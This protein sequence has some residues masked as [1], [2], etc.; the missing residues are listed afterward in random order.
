VAARRRSAT[1]SPTEAERH[2][3]GG[4]GGLRAR[5]LAALADAV[6][7][8]DTAGL[9]PARPFRDQAEIDSLD[10]L[11]FV[12]RLEQSLR[13]RVPDLDFPK[14]ASLDGALAYLAARQ[15]RAPGRRGRAP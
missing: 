9:D 5:V 15:V 4:R 1:K 10:F 14:L 3:A 13:V 7:G 12:Q 6:P 8:L 11:R 2:A